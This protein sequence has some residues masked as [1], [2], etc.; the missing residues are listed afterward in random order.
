[1][2]ANDINEFPLE[3]LYGDGE[4]RAYKSGCIIERDVWVDGG[5]NVRFTGQELI[6]KLAPGLPPDP[7]PKPS[8]EPADRANLHVVRVDFEADLGKL[9]SMVT[10]HPDMFQMVALTIPKPTAS[11]VVRNVGKYTVSN[12]VVRTAM[13]LSE[14]LDPDKEDALFVRRPEWQTGGIIGTGN[15]WYPNED[16]V[17]QT[18][19]NEFF[20]RSDWTD[21]VA[22]KKVFYIV[23]K[24]GCR[25]QYGILP[26][27][28]S[29]RRVSLK[30]GEPKMELCWAHNT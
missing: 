15:V 28:R 7:T 12:Y 17:V 13:I 1:M 20:Q 16:K 18:Q 25:D 2:R 11:I 10:L 29:C 9:E 8:T 19:W 22:G 26:E 5:I 4:S 6:A 23:T 30:D 24:S 3:I 14:E 27:T 21:L